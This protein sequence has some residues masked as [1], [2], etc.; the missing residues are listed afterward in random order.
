M[1]IMP[2]VSG[3]P[4][5]TATGHGND[6]RRPT[7]APGTIRITAVTTVIHA[8]KSMHSLFVGWGGRQDGRGHCFCTLVEVC[9]R[10]RPRHSP[11]PWGTWTGLGTSPR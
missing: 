5:A 9:E 4:A 7:R 2:N 1:P 6:I 11:L 3:A 10:P 8:A